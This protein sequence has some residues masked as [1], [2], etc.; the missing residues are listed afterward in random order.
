MVIKLNKR[1]VVGILQLEHPSSFRTVRSVFLISEWSSLSAKWDARLGD[2]TDA[3]SC[4]P[5]DPKQIE[6]DEGRDAW[7]LGK[8][9]GWE[10]S[11]DTEK[12]RLFT[13]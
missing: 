5:R 12:R 4:G 8:T 10:T 1:Q 11:N 6:W 2:V 3:F 9:R 7:E 13:T